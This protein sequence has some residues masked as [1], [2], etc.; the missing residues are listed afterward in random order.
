MPNSPPAIYSCGTHAPGWVNGP[1]PATPGQN[2]NGTVCFNWSG[3]SCMWSQPV[4]ITN[5]NGF[6]VYYLQPINWGCNGVYC[7]Q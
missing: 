3:N 6:Y 2:I 4:Q 1:N 5:C 7:G